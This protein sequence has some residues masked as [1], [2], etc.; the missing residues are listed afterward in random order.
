MLK[1]FVSKGLLDRYED[2]VLLT[3]DSVESARSTI[4]LLEDL[5]GW[6]EENHRTLRLRVVQDVEVADRFALA[7]GLC[8]KEANDN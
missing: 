3:P 1:T 8:H 6:M 5:E 2:V 7:L 4:V